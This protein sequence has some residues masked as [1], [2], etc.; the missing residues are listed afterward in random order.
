MSA[1]NAIAISDLCAVTEYAEKVPG[2][3]V[4]VCPTTKTAAR[5]SHL[6]A[7]AAPD[8]AFSGGRTHVLQNG[9]KV[10]V[11]VASHAV[12]VPPDRPFTA[13]FLAWTDIPDPP[14]SGMM[15]WKGRAASVITL[16]DVRETLS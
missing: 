10:S 8:G 7:A 4:L 13:M 6:L 14:M 1:Q 2:W 3:Y 12:F 15:R 9:S 16:S 11:A 5:M